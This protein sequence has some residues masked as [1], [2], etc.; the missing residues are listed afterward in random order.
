MATKKPTPTKADKSAAFYESYLEGIG[1][2]LDQ[3]E[4]QH[5]LYGSQNFRAEDKTTFGL[6]SL[7]LI[8]KG[9]IIPGGWYTFFGGE[10]SAKSTLA[11]TVL[12]NAANSKVPILTYYDFEGS[13]TKNTLFRVNGEDV[14]LPFPEELP[15]EKGFLDQYLHVDTVGGRSVKAQVHYGGLRDI[16]RIATATGEHLEGDNHPMLIRRGDNLA[17]IMIE[18]LQ[19]GDRV[20]RSKIAA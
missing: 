8:T 14:T 5:D 2:K 18:N 16:T 4:S 10:Q 1:T 7:D 15:A 13:V 20:I 9:G 6:L 19:V 12:A 11:Q 17:W 3:L